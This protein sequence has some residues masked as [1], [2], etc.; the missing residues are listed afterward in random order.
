MISIAASTKGVLLRA[1]RPYRSS[2]APPMRKSFSFSYLIAS[3][4]T[5]S[6]SILSMTT[7][8]WAQGSQPPVAGADLVWTRS[9]GEPI[10][11][12]D[13]LQNDVD[14]EGLPLTIT[15]VQAGEG[16]NVSL[17]EKNDNV[18]VFDPGWS[19]GG[20]GT[21][22]YQVTDESGDSSTGTVTVRNPFLLARG[23]YAGPLS[24]AS[25][26][27]NSAG[28]MQLSLSSSGVV[29]GQLR[30]GRENLRFKGLF[31]MDGS[32]VGVLRLP[33]GDVRRIALNL[34]V[35][36]SDQPISGTLTGGN[37]TVLINIPRLAFK[38]SNPP[39]FSG[40]FTVILPVDAPT[41]TTPQ[42]MGYGVL[43]VSS[44]GNASFVGKLGDGD[45]F[46]SRVFVQ[47][48]GS[49]P[50]FAPLY[51]NTGSVSGVLNFSAADEPARVGGTLDWYK[52]RIRGD[53]SYPAGFRLTLKPDGRRYV[54]PNVGAMP[55]ALSETV[56]GVPNASFLFSGSGFGAGLKA[57]VNVPSRPSSGSYRIESTSLKRLQLQTKIDARTGVFV[58]TVLQRNRLARRKFS[59]VLLQGTNLGAGVING[60]QRTGVVTLQPNDV[61]AATGLTLEY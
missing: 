45:S 33:N 4:F 46:S 37:E 25:S 32:F 41:S 6:A 29:S 19:F 49:V 3:A 51:K 30:F 36:G 53:R 23:T 44:G 55:L 9:V 50:V 20:Q 13:L 22:T 27:P 56:P 59:G 28:Y 31:E 1:R 24:G 21:F 35:D 8:G 10:R 47:P 15:A 57:L 58:G 14:P 11:L 2:S 12:I 40:D 26:V 5:T 39:P 43:K 16:G 18:V 38:T 42:G 60:A 61:S 34:P 54:A 7:S 48:D 17:D 52:P